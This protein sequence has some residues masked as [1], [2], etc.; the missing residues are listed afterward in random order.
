MYVNT[1]TLP[2]I[3]KTDLPGPSVKAARTPENLEP[4]RPGPVPVEPQVSSLHRLSVACFLFLGL[5]LAV[6]RLTG[7][8]DS[9]KLEHGHKMIC[10]GF[11]SLLGFG[12]GG[13]SY[14]NLLAS[15]VS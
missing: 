9:K 1:H 12:V 3:Q 10:D 7:T 6:S 11:A 4:R 15:T 13:W 8:V 14:S 5:G 2:D